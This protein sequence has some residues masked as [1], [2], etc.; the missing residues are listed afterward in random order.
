MQKSEEVV[1]KSI[2]LFIVILAFSVTGFAKKESW[3]EMSVFHM[4]S[5]WK[6][7]DGKDFQL[8]DFGGTPTVFAM[9]YTSCKHTCPMITSKVAQVQSQLPEKLKGKVQLALISFDPE[10]DTPENLNKYKKKRKLGKEWTLLTGT[11]SGIRQLAAVVGVN[12]KKEKSGDFSHSNIVTLL[13]QNGEVV[14]QVKDL[15]K[16]TDK[17]SAKIIELLK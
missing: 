3:P 5:K 13:D 8:K 17:M 10:Q 1:K 6:N 16:K 14:E 11:E 2:G 7:E 4:K 12:Y 9:V 15:S